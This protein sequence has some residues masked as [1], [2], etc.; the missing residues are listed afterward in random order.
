M[1]SGSRSVGYHSAVR[2][3]DPPSLHP[4]NEPGPQIFVGSFV[5]AGTAT[6]RREI[7]TG[8]GS[9]SFGFRL[10]EERAFRRF[11]PD[12]PEIPSR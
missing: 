1:A 7:S 12:I 9:F 3:P 5:V 2:G 11:P 10:V 8:L 4:S 6:K